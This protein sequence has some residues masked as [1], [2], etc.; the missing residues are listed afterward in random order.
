MFDGPAVPLNTLL[1]FKRELMKNILATIFLL[2]F[3]SGCAVGHKPWV[4]MKNDQIG[5]KVSVLDPTRFG[6]AGELIRADFLIAGKG[7]THTSADE[8]GNIIQHWDISEVLPKFSEH[9]LWPSLREDVV[10]KCLIYY[11]VDPET[12]VI[13]DW[14]FDKGGNPKS[15]QIWP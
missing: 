15:C 8:N 4:E 2:A 3:L 5:Q 13:K 7:F 6:N 10:G 12:N 11:I 14:G 1:G 9:P